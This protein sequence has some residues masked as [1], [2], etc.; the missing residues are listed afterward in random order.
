M[1]LMKRRL[2]LLAAC[3]A[4]ALAFGAFGAAPAFADNGPHKMGAGVLADGCA[5]CHRVH[6]AKT[7]MLTMEAQP[8]LCYTC[9]GTSGTGADTDV[10]AGVGRGT[11]P[12]ALRG[13]GFAYALIDS[14]HPES[15]R[16]PIPASTNVIPALPVSA[17]GTQ[18]TTSSHSVTGAD[19]PAWGMGGL[20][21]PVSTT[22]QLRCGSCHDPH[23]NGN[24]RILRPM[25]EQGQ[26]SL[27]AATPVVPFAG[28]IADEATKKYTTTN[29][30]LVED[31][32]VQPASPAAKVGFIGNVSQWCSTCHTRYLATRDSSG[33]T[34]TPA[35]RSRFD[36][37]DTT[38]MYRHTSSQTNQGGRSCIQ[39]HVAHGSNA[40]MGPF[41]GA[42]GNPDGSAGVVGDSKLLR[43]DNR[44]TCK[45]CHSQGG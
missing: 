42:V 21:T 5:G 23:G 36:S 38:F 9:H 18:A 7:D 14:S 43:V 17:T 1:G 22:I 39:C 10:Q 19:A 4:A 27:G 45:M 28:V 40:A 12:G 11:V 13:G 26:Q 32:T 30:W 37:G 15:T 6:T 25:P 44:G 8:Q 29:Y 41:S 24:Y 20:N 3:S 31:S 2:A 35:Q 34:T 16:S 33:A